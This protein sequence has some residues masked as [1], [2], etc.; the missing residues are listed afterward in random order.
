MKG[1]L[2]ALEIKA[3]GDPADPIPDKDGITDPEKGKFTP[4]P[5]SVSALVL[6]PSVKGLVVVNALTMG[7]SPFVDNAAGASVPSQSSLDDVLERLAQ[8]VDLSACSRAVVAIPASMVFFRHMDL[9][10]RSRWKIGQVL[11][12]ELDAVLPLS[13]EPH[14]SDFIFT[15]LSQCD[16]HTFLTAS[17][18]TQMV[19]TLCNSLEKRGISPILISSAGYLAS[20]LFLD[21]LPGKGFYLMVEVMPHCLVINGIFD[22]VIVGLRSIVRGSNAGVTMEMG[23]TLMLFRH[24]L[25]ITHSLLGCHIIWSDTRD[26]DLEAQLEKILAAPVVREDLAAVSPSL[27]NGEIVFD[28][29]AHEYLNAFAAARCSGKQGC[30][31]FCQKSNGQGAFVEKHMAQL[32][33]MSL[34]ILICF[35][36]VVAG[37]HM[38][39]R[40]LDNQVVAMD[41]QAVSIFKETFPEITT[42]VDPYMQMKIQVRQ[43][44]EQSGRFLNME[45]RFAVGNKI[46]DLLFELSSRIPDTI[47]VEISR[48]VFNDGRMV[49]SGDTDTYDSVDKMKTAIESSPLFTDVK[50]SNAAADKNEKCIRFKFI[51]QITDDEENL[52]TDRK[53]NS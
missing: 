24:R 26:K 9:P 39:I 19:D 14:V 18:S 33:T 11:P 46:T 23:R 6:K 52:P 1:Y 4:F 36:L 29:K 30:L 41:E 12:M 7:M 31:N 40:S 43:S 22:G 28:S 42:I 10:F 3:T 32:V 5:W 38:E 2:L 37:E 27:E 44:S 16:T 20:H 45:N 8:R 47:D 21:S 51:F 17:L 48:L 15:G 50:I 34:L 49:L 13:D 25:G 53:E 35:F